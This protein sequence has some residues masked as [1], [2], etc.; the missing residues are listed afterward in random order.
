MFRTTSRRIGATIG[1]LGGVMRAA[2]SFAPTLLTSA[3]ARESLYLAVDICLGACLASFYLIPTLKR[4]ARVGTTIALIGVIGVRLDRALSHGVLYAAAAFATAV[5]TLTLSTSLREARAIGIWVPTFFALS[6]ALGAIGTL[7]SGAGFAFVASGVLLGAA[8]AGLA[9][10]GWPS[11]SFV[12]SRG[13][14]VR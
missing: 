11:S 8:F 6:I 14:T 10:A 12:E 5:G 4:S 3:F 9:P 1:I 2:G 7:V 13:D